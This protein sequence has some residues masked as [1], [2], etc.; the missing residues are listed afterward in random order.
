MSYIYCLPDE[1]EG[2]ANDP[3]ALGGGACDPRVTV[4]LSNDE[5][6][7]SPATRRKQSVVGSKS[8]Q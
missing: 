6:K 4:I 7:Q 2:G 1:I 8:N 3:I 5:T